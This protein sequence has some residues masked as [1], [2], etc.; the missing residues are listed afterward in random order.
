MLALAWTAERLRLVPQSVNNLVSQAPTPVPTQQTPG[1]SGTTVT[2]GSS[3][4][5]GHTSDVPI[6]N[7]TSF[8]I[9]S[10]GDP[11]VL[12]HLNNGQFVAFDPLCPHPA[13]PVDYDPVTQHFLS[14]YH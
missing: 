10:N 12:I 1:L 6:N 7:A 14:P 4:I 8:T 11:G 9:P 5:I 3:T 2:N 13:S